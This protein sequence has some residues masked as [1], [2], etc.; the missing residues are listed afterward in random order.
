MKKMKVLNGK[1][2]HSEE[3]R[4]ALFTT[5][6]KC[7]KDYTPGS[8]P[9]ELVNILVHKGEYDSYVLRNP[10]TGKTTTATIIAYY[11]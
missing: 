1:I 3:Y 9:F 10:E 7:N 2:L 6:Y 11:A 4:P 8:V 5:V